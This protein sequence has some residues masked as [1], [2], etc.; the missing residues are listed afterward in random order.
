MIVALAVAVVVVFVVAKP[1][2]T[3][4]VVDDLAVDNGERGVQLERD[5][6]ETGQVVDLQ[7][8]DELIAQLAVVEAE[9][10]ANELVAL[11]ELGVRV[12]RAIRAHEYEREVAAI[13]RLVSFQLFYLRFKLFALDILIIIVVVV[14]VVVFGGF[15]VLLLL[16]CV[17][18]VYY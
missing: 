8:L 18:F 1:L 10:V 16:V 12:A 15:V 5:N 9:R 14:V 3:V 6:H 2:E 11:Q 4:L 17:F 13:G 7:M